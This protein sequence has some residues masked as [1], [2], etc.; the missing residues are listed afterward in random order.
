VI[1]NP[2]SAIHYRRNLLLERDDEREN[3]LTEKLN[4][5]STI[6]SGLVAIAP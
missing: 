3:T 5:Q 1:D 2:F 6:D 4:M